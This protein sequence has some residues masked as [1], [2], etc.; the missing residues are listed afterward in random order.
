MRRLGIV[1]VG[2]ALLDRDVEGVV[3]RL[4]PDAPVPVVDEAAQSV[5]PGG[6]GLAALLLAD[7]G[8]DV[9]LITALA[10]DRAGK[11]AIA[12]LQRA[13]V[14]VVNLGLE[15]ATPEKVRV[16]ASG[17]SL[18]RIDRGGPGRPGPF[19][20]GAGEVLGRAEGVLV[21]D[22]GRGLTAD[23][24]L[25]RCISGLP[26]GIPIVWDP[27]PRGAPPLPHVRLVTP[28]LR[29]AEHF[30]DGPARG[31]SAIAAAG[32][33]GRRLLAA[34][35]AGAVGITM[36]PKGAVLVEGANPPLV[37]PAP[38]VSNGDPCGAGD[39]FAASAVRALAAG[40][41]T[42]EAV[43]GA[44]MDASRFV[45][46][47]GAGATTP[48]P[49][50]ATAADGRR[51]AGRTVTDASELARRIRSQGGSVVATGGCFDLL[52]AGHIATLEA[53]R[54]LGDCLIVLLNSDASVRRLKGPDR[55]LVPAGDRVALL[56]AL[57][58][59]DGVIVFDEDTPE[60][61]LDR[62]RPDLFAKGGDY[63]LGPLPEAALLES[64]GGEAVVLPYLQGRSTT[65]LLQEAA[66]RDIP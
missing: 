22:Y 59:V 62:L 25:R 48:T 40:A 50:P 11:E 16:R 4:S 13:G 54:R 56:A 61:A 2:D 9:V 65:H 24:D 20:S 35:R 14:E 6:A 7:D 1:V 39:R 37:A 27:H 15:G 64:W 44:V 34:W 42:S 30:G 43:C 28:N 10:S 3:D 18:L 51:G 5:R 41:L 8:C 23:D 60:T 19:S 17:R 21:S 52:H 12:L 36:G 66:R 49:A 29:E 26:A 45:E 31:H 33:L 38:A 47:G 63:A 32:A 53:A 46:A 58:A 55:P 57:E